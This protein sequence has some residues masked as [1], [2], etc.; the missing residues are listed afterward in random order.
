MIDVTYKA[1][2]KSVRLRSSAVLNNSMDVAVEV[3]YSTDMGDVN[4]TIA[5]KTEYVFR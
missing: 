5:G 3:T 4:T 1:G 2:A